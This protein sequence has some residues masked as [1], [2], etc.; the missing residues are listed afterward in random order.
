MTQ[1]H[2]EHEPRVVASAHS[3]V[4]PANLESHVADCVICAETKRV[5]QL[6]LDHAATV[7]SQ[8]RPPAANMVWQRMQAQRQQHALQRA[9]RYMAWMRVLAALYAIVLAA[10]Y[11]PQLW[12]MQSA[13]FSMTL[14]AFSSGTV[15]AGVL[16]AI[17]A[18][19]LGSC[20][21]VLLGSRINFRLRS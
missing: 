14:S 8:S 12:H 3:G 17:V 11:L 20:C 9:T 10:W 7:S 16:T 15:L 2:C 18:V 6:F 4:W 13:P 1:E 5:T 21:L 19:A